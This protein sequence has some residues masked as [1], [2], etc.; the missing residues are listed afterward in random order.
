ML[1]LLD[2]AISVN[3]LY[4]DA[5]KQGGEQDPGFRQQ[6]QSFSDGVLIGLSR[7]QYMHADIQVGDQEIQDYF[8]KHFRDETELTERLRAMVEA[9]IRKH[10]LAARKSGLRAHV[11]DG[12]TV[13]IDTENLQPEDD[14]LR[15]E[16]DVIA[17]YDGRRVTWGETKVHLTT[18]NNQN[19][20]LTGQKPPLVVD[21]RSPDE[22]SAG[23]IPNSVNIPVPLI[24]KRLGE[25]GNASDLV[26][27]CNDS[28]LT[29]VAEQMLLR[30]GMKG[31]FHLEGGLNGWQEAGLE[32]ENGLPE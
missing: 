25:M 1:T 15:K 17:E 10:K 2:K 26:L 24:A 5:L 23:H 19:Q 7:K 27:Y 32:L 30:G 13:K 28:R 9:K 21:V 8:A 18:L 29:R 14:A 12:V 22:Y 11:R 4:L 16:G 31:F 20:L 3:L 6:L